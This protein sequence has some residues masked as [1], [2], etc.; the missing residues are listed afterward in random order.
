MSRSEIGFRNT[1]EKMRLSLNPI[2]SEASETEFLAKTRFLYFYTLFNLT[3]TFWAG[4]R[5]APT[6]A[7]F[8]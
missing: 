2:Y 7:Q 6:L 8:L 3:Q 4:T 1:S 5:P